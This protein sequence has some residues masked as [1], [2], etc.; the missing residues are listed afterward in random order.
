VAMEPTVAAL[1]VSA[2]HARRIAGSNA[3]F[4]YW[5][6]TKACARHL[7]FASIL[8]IPVLFA[9]LASDKK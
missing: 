7:L 1:D 5:E 9:L 8:Y 2:V 6:L 3:L 4:D